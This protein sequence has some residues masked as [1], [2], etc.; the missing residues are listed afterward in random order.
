VAEAAAGASARAG[1]AVVELRGLT[2]RYGRRSI[3]DGV[4]LSVARGSVYA[5]LGRNGV[6]KSSVLRCLLGQQKPSA[7]VAPLRAGRRRADARSLMERV[8]YVPEEPDAPPELCA[9]ELVPFCGRLN[10]PA[11]TKR[12]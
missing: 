10:V 1:E 6:G 2:V 11:G 5:L 12:P 8:G 4:S 9:R 7:G 3:L